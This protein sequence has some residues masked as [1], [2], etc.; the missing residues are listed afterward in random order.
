[1]VIGVSIIS[2]SYRPLSEVQW[3]GFGE[4]K[5]TSKGEEQVR[6]P[7][8]KKIVKL[9]ET[10][11][12]YTIPEKTLWD[13]LELLSNL[14]IPIFVV[15]LTYEFQRNEQI[16]SEERTKFE[17]ERTT[18]ILNEEVLQAYIDRISELLIDKNVKTL[19]IDDPLRDVALDVA[20]TRTLSVLRRLDKDGERKGNIIRF[21]IDAGFIAKLKL[22]L[23][24]VD[25][26]NADLRG[27]N[28]SEANLINANLTN[29]NLSNVNFNGANLSGANLISTNLSHAY[30]Y[31]TNLNGVN[32]SNANLSN[33]NLRGANLMG[34]NLSGA[35]L[36]HTYL[37]GANLSRV[38]LSGANLSETYLSGTNLNGANLSSANLSGTK[39][40]H[41]IYGT[42]ENI[43]TEQ[44]K[45]ANNWEKAVYSPQFRKK[46]GLPPG[47]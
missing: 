28:L 5:I 46:L 1:M 44:I 12:T 10:K 45:E 26:S 17:K 22:D 23:S 40:E 37:I 15:F 7:K 13:W 30:L 41:Y 16:K 35:N 21:L 2:F 3:I 36:N 19:S 29:A 18:N 25:L 42:A 24:N 27:T 14:A 9:I 11:T 33:A 20:R 6:N 31:D 47:N 38:D 34:V 43:T 4:D 32:L 8:N 39:F